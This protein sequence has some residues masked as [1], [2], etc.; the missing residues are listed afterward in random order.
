MVVL[1]VIFWSRMHGLMS[2]QSKQSVKG[3]FEQEFGL[4]RTLLISIHSSD[5][6]SYSCRNTG[7]ANGGKC[8][9]SKIFYTS[10]DN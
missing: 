4:F 2:K 7:K 1:N 9:I 3:C 6:T 10:H 8:R 5:D